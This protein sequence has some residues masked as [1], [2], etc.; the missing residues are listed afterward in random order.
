ML[1]F[2]FPSFKAAAQP[3]PSLFNTINFFTVALLPTMSA[4]SEQPSVV[5]MDVFALIVSYYSQ[6]TV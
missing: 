4:F 5:D 2:F 3:L 6:C 1:L